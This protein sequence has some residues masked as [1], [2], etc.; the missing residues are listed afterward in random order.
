MCPFTYPW[1]FG[2]KAM[3]VWAEMYPE[4]TRTLPADAVA[5]APVR[6]SQR[7]NLSTCGVAAIALVAMLMRVTKEHV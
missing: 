6:Q 1:T 7:L 2:A 4:Y 3:A 5:A